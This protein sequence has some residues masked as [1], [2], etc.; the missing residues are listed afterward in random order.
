MKKTVLVIAV[1]MLFAMGSVV[2]AGQFG[3]LEPAAKEGRVALGIGYFR[4]SAEWKPKDVGEGKKVT[5]NKVYLQLSYS[6]VKN[7]ELYAR[8]GGADLKIKDVFRTNEE[9]RAMLLADGVTD[10]VVTGLKPDFKEGLRTF[11]TI[12][13]KGFFNVSDSFGIGPFAQV[14]MYSSYKDRNSGTVT[15]TIPGVGALL[16]TGTEELKIKNL[17]DINLGIG[18][19]GKIGDLIVYGGPFA[20][21]TRA[22]VDWTEVVTGTREG[23]PFTDSLSRSITI[24]EENNIGGFAGL[25]LPLGKGLNFEVEGQIKSRFSMGGALTYAF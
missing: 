21:W 17:R 12:G 23:V 10:P 24:E 18:L 5:Q 15:G 11:G 14:S 1:L 20:Y 19:Q 4:S 22:K 3:P 13:V 25:R 9:V 2:Y 8:V 7:L 6:P 16:A